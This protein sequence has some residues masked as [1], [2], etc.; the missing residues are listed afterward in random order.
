MGEEKPHGGWH[1][2]VACLQLLVMAEGCAGALK[3]G[4]GLPVQ[5]W[6]WYTGTGLICVALSLF[7]YGERLRGYRRY[8]ILAGTLA[9]L[10]VLFFSQN[11]WRKGGLLLW[12]CVLGTMDERYGGRMQAE[13]VTMDAWTLTW[14][15][16]E[17]MVPLLLL[18]AAVTVY[19][20]DGLLLGALLLPGAVSLLLVGKTPRILP[21][22][23]LL[24]GCVTIC[25]SARSV[26][27]TKFWGAEG[28]QW[29]ERNRIRCE[30]IRS[31]TVFISAIAVVALSVPGF[32]LIRPFLELQLAGVQSRTAEVEGRLTGSLVNLFPR[33]TAGNVKLRVEGVGG[34]VEDG[35]IADAE[36]Y[37]IQGIEDLKLICSGQPRETVYLRGFV[38]SAYEHDRWL[39]MEG[40][41]FDHAAQNWKVEEEPRLYIQNLPFLRALYAFQKTAAGEGAEGISGNGPVQ[42]LTVQRINANPDYTYAPYYAYYNSYYKVEGGDGYV[43]GQSQWEDIFSYFPR[44]DY[45]ERMEAWKGNEEQSSVLDQMEASYGGYVR[46]HYLEVPEGF[47]ELQAVCARQVPGGR[48]PEDVEEITEY[49]QDFL[50]EQYTYSLRPPEAPEG[51]DAL[52]WFLEG[53]G[54]GNSMHFASAATLMFRMFGVPARYV[55]GYAAPRN[56]FTAQPDGT[57]TAVLQ[58]DNSH[59]WTEI[60]REGVGWIPVEVTPG[61]LGAA[62]E[63][64][65]RGD[66]VHTGKE[67][68]NDREETEDDAAEDQEGSGGSEPEI[69]DEAPAEAFIC[70]LTLLLAAGGILWGG[71]YGALVI[72]RRRVPPGASG[73]LRGSP[74]RAR[75]QSIFRAYYRRLCRLGMPSDVEA[76]SARFRREAALRHSG[77][78]G[79]ELEELLR[80]AF[81]SSYSDHRMTE[82]DVALMEGYYRSLRKNGRSLRNR[83]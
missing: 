19:L 66:P 8:G 51:E 68:M 6:I 36:G 28:S 13:A 29:F 42:E 37:R 25:V 34:G 41:S 50:R 78:T 59:A 80:L 48:I 44:T 24:A 39:V 1:C 31:K 72:R 43:A 10:A 70:W 47:E 55:V 71:L 33:L 67:G 23:L 35:A 18:L 76:S 54:T 26:P 4:L 21:L 82:K 30:N 38:G 20:P 58:E 46:A 32:W 64:T 49:I 57:Y 9:Y 22:F 63:V 3:T 40:S 11:I 79:E 17:L 69:A 45:L 52:H 73:S 2:A 60:Y 61:E 74:E 65:G 27:G 12:N 7:F 81:E 83:S 15:L 5:S 56:L 75:I 62:T 14:F 53:S 77:L 16:L